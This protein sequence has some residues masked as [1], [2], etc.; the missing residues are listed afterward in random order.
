MG[1]R[2]ANSGIVNSTLNSAT[3]QVYIK[4]WFFNKIK[5]EERGFHIFN[6]KFDVIDETEKAYKLSIEMNSLDG[7]Y[8][9]VKSRWIP[10]SASMSEEEYKTALNDRKT[11]YEKAIDF[12]KNKGV[13]GVRKGMKK[14]TILKKIRDAGFEYEY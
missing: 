10:K 7:E 1:G 2:G 3:K 4:D 9:K 8:N 5:Y 6:G 11:R 14:T 12:A 13:K